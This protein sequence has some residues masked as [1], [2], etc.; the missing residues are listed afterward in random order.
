MVVTQL[1]GMHFIKMKKTIITLGIIISL[2]FLVY[3]FDITTYQTGLDSKQKE[4]LL[5]IGIGKL[6]IIN[7]TCKTY[8][9]DTGECLGEDGGIIGY[10]EPEMSNCN[11]IDEFTCVSEI[12]GG[13]IQGYQLTL[14]KKYCEEYELEFYNGDC[15][16]EVN[17][18][19]EQCTDVLLE[20]EVC[21]DVNSTECS[22]VLN[23]IYYDYVCEN[24]V[25]NICSNQP[26]QNCNPYTEEQCSYILVENSIQYDYVCEDIEIANCTDV[27]TKVCNDIIVGTNCLEYE[28]LNRTTSNCTSWYEKSQG[29]LEDEMKEKMDSLLLSFIDAENERVSR[30]DTILTDKIKVDMG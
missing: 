17:V 21:K 10:D 4:D 14:I 7:H 22:Y 30:T 20:E 13:G 2:A 9:E 29:E 3:A 27:Y 25:N 18:T 12:N 5:N 6:P 28:Q 15:I 8:D 26:V 11:Q 19:E 1:T 24:V 23:G 16:N